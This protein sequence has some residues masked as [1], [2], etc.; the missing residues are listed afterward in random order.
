MPTLISDGITDNTV[1]FQQIFDE[2]G[3]AHI[4]P[5]NYRITGEL[6]LA[7]PIRLTGA[8]PNTI[9]RTESTTAPIL[10]ITAQGCSVEHLQFNAFGERALES[11]FVDIQAH[12]TTL[13]HF[14]MV[15]AQG[16]I[17]TSGTSV[18]ISD[19]VI[20]DTLAS[21]TGILVEGGFDVRV[22][23]VMMNSGTPFRAG[24]VVRQT[25]D[26]TLDTLNIMHAGTCLLVQPLSGQT[27]ASVWAHNSFFDT[28]TYGT[29]LHAG[30]DSY[31]V[32]AKFTQCWFSSHTQHGALVMGAIH[33][34]EFTACEFNLNSLDGLHVTGP[35]RD[36][37]VL[38]GSAG[39]N[40]GAGF[41]F[42]AG[43]SRFS[44]IGAAS[45]SGRGL[46]P[47][48]FGAYI[49]QSCSRYRLALN[50]FNDNSVMAM[51]VAGQ[52]PHAVADNLT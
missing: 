18:R 15:H 50:D 35:A 34:A 52:E 37:H 32:R 13:S 2:G 44:V 28:S 40:G 39:A 43:A 4:P 12:D 16:G 51:A 31:I 10:R 26:I 8:G 19:G 9:L 45:G 27:A 48:A 23:G 29:V 38:G 3:E 46:G 36:V 25:G 42:S 6:V 14:T 49:D 22:Y 5:G 41:S 20:F 11:W 47:N 21:G 30:G 24:I 17:R 1:A 7:H 33:G